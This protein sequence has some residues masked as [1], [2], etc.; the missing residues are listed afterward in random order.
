MPLSSPQVD[1][2]LGQGCEL[3]Y[4]PELRE[5]RIAGGNGRR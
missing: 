2:G 5:D 4:Q 3:E 1:D